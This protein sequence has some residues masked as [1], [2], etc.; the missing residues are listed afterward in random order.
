MTHYMAYWKWKDY[1]GRDHQHAY[2]SRSTVL[3]GIEK[4]DVL[5]LFTR[6]PDTNTIHMV[7]RIVVC[8]KG[9]TRSHKPRIYWVQGQ[10][11]LRSAEGWG[12]REDWLRTVGAVNTAK[13]TSLAASSAGKLA[14]KFQQPR[15][16]S[17]SS[18]PVL[19]RRWR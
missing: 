6:K 4:D 18:I 19:E 7:Q 13:G 1:L 11:E 2:H 17:P 5:W 3:E 10:G 9:R 15:G 12:R 16:I 14:L 8:E